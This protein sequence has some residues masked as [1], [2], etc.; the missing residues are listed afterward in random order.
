MIS[1]ADNNTKASGSRLRPW[2]AAAPVSTA[3]DLSASVA[4]RGHSPS[5]VAAVD[6]LPRLHVESA[7]SL[8]VTGLLRDRLPVEQRPY[9]RDLVAIETV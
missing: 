1:A 4:T 9:L 8:S 2:R 5:A 6:A 3:A 7:W